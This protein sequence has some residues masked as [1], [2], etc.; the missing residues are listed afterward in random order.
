M[1]AWHDDSSVRDRAPFYFGVAWALYLTV[2]LG[3]LGW[4]L[5]RVALPLPGLLP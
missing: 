1:A 2:L 4:V 5:Y 3:L